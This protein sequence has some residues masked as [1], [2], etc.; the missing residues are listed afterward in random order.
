MRLLR[1]HGLVG[2]NKNLIFGY[3]SRLDTLQAVVA[4]NA[5][6]KIKNITKKRTT[7][8]QVENLI[9]SQKAGNKSEKILD[10]NISFEKPASWT[11]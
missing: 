6:G 11:I 8:R 4:L 2:R 7:A 9:K 5:L 3:N 1:N 10:P